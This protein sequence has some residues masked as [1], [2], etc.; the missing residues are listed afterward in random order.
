LF[1][2][3]FYWVFVFMPRMCEALFGVPVFRPC[4]EICTMFA[5]LRA[6]AGCV[7]YCAPCCVPCWWG[8]HGGV[9]VLLGCELGVYSRFWVGCTGSPRSEQC[10]AEFYALR[11]VLFSG[12]LA[13]PYLELLC[14]VGGPCATCRSYGCV[15]PRVCATRI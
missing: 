10:F 12:V 8:R 15:A 13:M 4:C 1:Q 11:H 9:A 2:Q 3:G 14:P 5:L 6:L 7:S